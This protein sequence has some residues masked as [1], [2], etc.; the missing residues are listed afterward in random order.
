MNERLTD[1]FIVSYDQ[2]PDKDSAVL[3]VG[4]RNGASFTIINAF[5]D[6]EATELYKKLTTIKKKEETTD[7]TTE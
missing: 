6:E 7:G 2:L 3:I 5:Q 4:K 1:S